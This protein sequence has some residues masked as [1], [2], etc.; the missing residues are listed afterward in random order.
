MQLGGTATDE[1][2]DSIRD[3]G[4][5][6]L[7]YVPHQAFFVYGDGDAIGKVSR[8]SRVRWVGEYVASQKLSPNLDFANAAKANL[9]FRRRRV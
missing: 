6:V 9:P 3:A 4:V 8:H 5:E 2:L 1:W 7:Q